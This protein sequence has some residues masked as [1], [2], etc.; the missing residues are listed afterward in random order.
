[1]STPTHATDRA[2]TQVPSPRRPADPHLA[3]DAGHSPG[4]RETA[5]SQPLG[6][7]DRHAWLIPALGIACVVAV[8]VSMVL[9]TWIAGGGTPFDR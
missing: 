1:M 7:F 8:F 5:Q 2:T 3:T 6:M 9:L 4:D